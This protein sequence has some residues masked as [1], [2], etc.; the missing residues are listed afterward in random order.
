MKNAVE[1]NREYGPDG[2]VLKS[3]YAIG[4]IVAWMVVATLALWKGVTL[5]PPTFWAFFKP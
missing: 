1:I 4:P 2:K 3:S 5:L